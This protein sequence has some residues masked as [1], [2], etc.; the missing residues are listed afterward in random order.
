MNYS[1]TN[2]MGFIGKKLHFQ[3]IS[4]MKKDSM[5]TKNDF[6]A[7]PHFVYSEVFAQREHKG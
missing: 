3:S 7:L 5:D 1:R 4:V 6:L 2:T